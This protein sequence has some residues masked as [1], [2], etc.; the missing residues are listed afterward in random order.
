MSSRSGRD[1]WG[2]RRRRLF[3]GAVLL[4]AD[5]SAFSR[6]WSWRA[7]FPFSESDISLVGDACHPKRPHLRPP[8]QFAAVA[9]SPS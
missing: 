1:V 7:T 6:A 8:P 3:S 2:F 9:W 4:A 5:S